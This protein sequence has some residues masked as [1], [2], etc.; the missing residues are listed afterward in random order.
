MPRCINGVCMKEE[1][2]KQCDSN[3]IKIKWDES[4]YGYSVKL[5][6]CEKCGRVTILKY[7]E[8]PGIDINGDLRWY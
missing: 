8:D 5:A 1:K 4:G 6:V 3:K 7:I 2:C